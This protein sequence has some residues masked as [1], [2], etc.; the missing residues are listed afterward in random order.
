MKFTAQHGLD[1]RTFT[2]H[3]PRE[4][5]ESVSELSKKSAEKHNGYLTF[6]IELPHKPRTTGPGSQSAHLHGHLKQLAEH[7]G[8]LSLEEMKQLMKWDNITWPRKRVRIHGREVEIPISEADADTKVESDAIE[9]C[10]QRAS[11]EGITLIEG[12]LEEMSE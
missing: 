12:V 10:H 5:G 8:T 6:Y 2:I 11:E 9:W 7:Y 3:L 4:L 1:G